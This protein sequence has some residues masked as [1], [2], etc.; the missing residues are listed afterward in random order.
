MIIIRIWK[1]VILADA[2][3]SRRINVIMP[4]LYEKLN[5]GAIPVNL[6]T[7]PTCWKSFLT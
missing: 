6:L 5:T 2:G 1:R 4:F 7:A 3:R